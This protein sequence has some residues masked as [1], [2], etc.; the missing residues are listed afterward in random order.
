[1][2]GNSER[3][4]PAALDAT[5]GRALAA[6]LATVALDLHAI[7]DR[8][9]MIDKI[10]RSSVSTVP[11][12][13]GGGIALIERR[14]ITTVAPTGPVSSRLHDLQAEIG[15]GPCLTSL[16]KQHTVVVADLP[17]DERWPRLAPHAAT[18]GVRSTLS[19]QLYVHGDNLGALDLYSGDADAFGEDSVL[20]GD[21]FARHASV[22]LAH[23]GQV[24]HLNHALASRDVIGQAKGILMQ[25]DGLTAQDAFAMLVRVSQETNLKLVDVAGWLADEVEKRAERPK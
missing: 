9:T 6:T 23:A 8:D 22:A 14:G 7:Q 5:D 12:A 11:G 1:M 13:D 15:E 16:W 18:L 19:F 25:R 24:R 20:I 2:T 10:V 3:P 17:A 4:D 21:L